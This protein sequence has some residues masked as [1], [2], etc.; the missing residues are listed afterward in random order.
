MIS[1]GN[2]PCDEF[3]VDPSDYSNKLSGYNLDKVRWLESQIRD[4]TDDFLEDP[5]FYILEWESLTGEDI[6]KKYVLDIPQE[7]TSFLDQSNGRR[8][9]DEFLV[10]YLPLITPKGEPVNYDDSRLVTEFLKFN[11]KVYV[12]KD[13]LLK[14]L[15]TA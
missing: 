8:R 7:I 12:L 2:L 4:R 3:A 5:E 15:Q 13:S 9:T 6:P 14:K 10:R 1:I 11:Q